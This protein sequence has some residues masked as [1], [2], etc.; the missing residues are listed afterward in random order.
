M[1]ACRCVDIKWALVRS[2]KVKV[3]RKIEIR[4]LRIECFFALSVGGKPGCRL[5]ER[6]FC[7][8]VA[9]HCV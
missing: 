7:T 6:W 4:I 2:L 3:V 8:I 9:A 1:C 5:C